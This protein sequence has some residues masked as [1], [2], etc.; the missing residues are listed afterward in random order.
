MSERFTLDKTNHWLHISS[1]AH[2]SYNYAHT[3]VTCFAFLVADTTAKRAG[4]LA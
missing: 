1:R 3:H 2:V 4:P